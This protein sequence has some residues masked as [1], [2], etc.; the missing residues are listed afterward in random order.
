M[1]SELLKQFNQKPIAYFPIYRE[2]TGSTTAGILLS[3]LM[4]WFSMKDKIFKTDKDI[5]EETMLTERELKTAKNALK[6]LAFLKITREGVPAKTYYEIDW[7][8]FEMTLT[9]TTINREQTKSQTRKDERAKLDRTN[10]PNCMGRKSQTHICNS[11]TENTTENTTEKE[12]DKKENSLVEANSKKS[13]TSKKE[14]YTKSNVEREFK[15][16]LSAEQR[17]V[18]VHALLKDKAVNYE[19]FINHHTSKGS[20]FKNWKSA[21]N[22]WLINQEKWYQDNWRDRTPRETTRAFNF[23]KGIEEIE[24]FDCGMYNSD[25]LFVTKDREIFKL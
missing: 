20:K 23:G 25:H 13:S 3:Q 2:L 6:K 24:G 5:R 7:E 18:F 16:L 8:I 11:L 22:T 17:A 14:T 1:N 19:A 10:E 12:K 15:D 9:Q 4:F 21:Y